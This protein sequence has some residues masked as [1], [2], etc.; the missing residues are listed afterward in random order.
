MLTSKPMGRGEAATILVKMFG[1]SELGAQRQLVDADMEPGKW[2]GNDIVAVKRHGPAD[3]YYVRYSWENLE[4]Y[5]SVRTTT[6]KE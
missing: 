6:T 2:K 5:Q 1:A 4:A 3:W